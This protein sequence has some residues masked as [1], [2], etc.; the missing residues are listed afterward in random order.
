[1]PEVLTRPQ[2]DFYREHGYLVI[3]GRIPSDTIAAIRAEIVRFQ[4][5]AR[6]MTEIRRKD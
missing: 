2:I 4:D 1:M 3:E 5:M 6:N